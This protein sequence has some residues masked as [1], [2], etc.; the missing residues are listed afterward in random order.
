MDLAISPKPPKIIQIRPEMIKTNKETWYT[1]HIPQEGQ[2]MKILKAWLLKSSCYGNERRVNN[3]K[4]SDFAL[5]LLLHQIKYV[6]T[7]NEALSD[8]VCSQRVNCRTCVT[9]SVICLGLGKIQ[10]FPTE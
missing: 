7:N 10:G 4:F 6:N 8:S 3:T 5:I 2:K 1:K 9:A